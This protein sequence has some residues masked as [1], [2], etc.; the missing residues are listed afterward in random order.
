M[1]ESSLASSRL[2]PRQVTVR[3]PAVLL[4]AGLLW[5]GALAAQE[6][7]RPLNYTVSAGLS[8]A[9]F[10]HNQQGRAQFA[11]LY[12]ARPSTYRWTF[13]L[14]HASRFGDSGFGLGVGYM[15]LFRSGL[16]LSA[17]VNT[18]TG[19]FLYPKYQ[20]GVSA[21]KPILPRRN[22]IPSLS[23]SFRQSKNDLYRNTRLLLGFTWYAPGPWIAGGNVG[24]A[25]GWP[26]ST[27]SWFGSLGLSYALWMRM[28]VGARIGYGDGSY[29]LVPGDFVV[30]YAYW[31]YSAH[32]SKYLSPSLVFTLT[33]GHDNWYGGGTVGLK[34]S[35]S[36]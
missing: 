1:K 28:S 21:S 10:A 13:G 29:M 30:D 17:G 2:G 22:L 4:L 34:V 3:L 7:Q 8:F 6:S 5:P 24:H 16:T 11:T 12:V 23:L 20:I 14:S 25:L 32:F 33:A 31:S 19:D 26:G 36:W 9:E 27:H 18:G 15:R 35:K